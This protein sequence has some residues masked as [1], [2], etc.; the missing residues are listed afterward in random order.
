MGSYILMVLLDESPEIFDGLF[1]LMLPKITAKLNV[2]QNID[3]IS[4]N[5]RSLFSIASC[6]DS[7]D[8]IKLWK[9]VVKMILTK[10]K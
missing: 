8:D 2:E 1:S 9:D 5:I 3:I 6:L 4:Y 10:C 7:D